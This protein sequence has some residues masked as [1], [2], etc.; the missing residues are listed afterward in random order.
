MKPTSLTHP[1]DWAVAQKATP[2]QT[3][4]GDRHLVQPHGRGVLLAVVDGIGHG[5]EAGRAAAI[6][7]D[8][9]LQQPGDS[10]HALTKRCH[11]ALALTRGVVMTLVAL[12]LDDR[13][14]TWCGVGNVEARLF[15][16][17][18]GFTTPESAL[19]RGGTVGSQLPVLYA[20]VI[21]VNPGDVLI[22]VSDGIRPDYEHDVPV[23]GPPQ[24]IAD[25]ILQKYYKGTDDALVLV[26][27]INET[28]HA[29]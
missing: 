6:A 15:R 19:L 24:R 1:V 5:P 4:S 10:V 11:A 25:H 9:L 17:E 23:K 7:V 18:A 2:G 22:M 12:D 14:I 28:N 27:R 26:A 8:A 3:V 16:V 21:P 20:N 29:A 13:T